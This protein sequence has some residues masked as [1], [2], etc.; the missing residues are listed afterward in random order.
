MAKPSEYIEKA[1]TYLLEN[2]VK[3]NEIAKAEYKK[4]RYT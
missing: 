4:N 2:R 3:Y 1:L